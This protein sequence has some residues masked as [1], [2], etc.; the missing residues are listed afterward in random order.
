MSS[1]DKQSPTIRVGLFVPVELQKRGFLSR[2]I[3]VELAD[4]A[5]ESTPQGVKQ[6]QPWC[7]WQGLSQYL[8]C[9]AF[10]HR[11]AKEMPKGNALTLEQVT[12]GRFYS[13]GIIFFAQ[14]LVDNVAVWLCE[15]MPLS[16]SGGERHFLSNLFKRELARKQPAATEELEKHDAFLR[17]INKYRQVWIH[18]ISGGAIPFSDVSPF[19]QPDRAQKTLAVPL[20]PVIQPDQENWTERAK[21]CPVCI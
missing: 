12:P 16:V 2:H 1:Q 7:R 14:A 18:T 20:D 6:I 4:R 17:E 9:L 11:S 15:A 21:Q 10:A 5:L 13:V 3:F 8:D 19:E